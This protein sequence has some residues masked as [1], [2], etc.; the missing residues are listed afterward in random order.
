M[1]DLLQIGI[2]IAISYVV[3]YAIGYVASKTIVM[4]VDDV[5]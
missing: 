4:I 1:T 2:T 3:G 5:M